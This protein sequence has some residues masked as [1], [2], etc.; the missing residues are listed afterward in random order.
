V[1]L[2]ATLACS[3]PTDPSEEVAPEP[4]PAATEAPP[5]DDGALL[6]ITLKVQDYQVF[7]PFSKTRALHN[8][9]KVIST[10]AKKG[11]VKAKDSF[12]A[13]LVVDAT[14]NSP[15][16]LRAPDLIGE[17]VMKGAHGTV[18]CELDPR[19]YKNGRGDNHLSYDP[20]SK[21]PWRDESKQTYEKPWR[22]GETIRM[23]VREDCGNFFV[24]DTELQEIATSFK[25]VAR[26]MLHPSNPETTF[27]L[28]DP[29]APLVRS[30]T[31][32]LDLPPDALVLQKVQLGEEWAFAAGDV[33]LRW[34]GSRILRQTLG[35]LGHRADTL[36]RTDLPS[37]F[38]EEAGS[39]QELGFTVTEISMRHWTDA[40]KTR[41][42]RRDLSVGLTIGLDS[43]ALATR[44][45]GKMDGTNPKAAAAIKKGISTETKRLT[46]LVP[47]NRISLV[48]TK[49]ELHPSNGTEAIKACAQLSADADAEL[50]LQ[51]SL[52]RY[53]IPVGMILRSRTRQAF[54]PVAHQGLL[55][56]DPR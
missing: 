54:L 3:D 12:G 31:I 2:L 41:K 26:S 27:P 22:P 38:T 14:N 36:S 9:A 35:G 25:V 17:F 11:M 7:H 46:S 43:A 21:V 24:Y 39:F 49:R 28:N 13:G 50:Q 18:R 34:D 37:D 52:D 33:V 53:E 48:T 4:R 56:F 19:R 1:L 10:K 6:G 8:P 20:T 44:I 15:H 23:S 51:Y 45:Q 5:T 47:C 29:D 16:L 55:S 30:D 42:G 40:E 32:T